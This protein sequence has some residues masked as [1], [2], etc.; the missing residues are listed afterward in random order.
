[1]SH[2]HDQ[3]LFCPA[4]G[5]SDVA[6][7]PAAS[8]QAWAK[9]PDQIVVQETD[10]NP[11]IRPESRPGIRPE[12]FTFGFG[13]SPQ[14]QRIRTTAQRRAE[15]PLNWGINSNIFDYINGW[16]P[17]L[18]EGQLP[19][20]IRDRVPWSGYLPAQPAAGTSDRIYEDLL[21]SLSIRRNAWGVGFASLGAHNDDGVRA[22]AHT[23]SIPDG[24]VV[25]DQCLG[26]GTYWQGDQGFYLC[27]D[28]YAM[29]PLTQPP[30]RAHH[31]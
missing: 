22:P 21:L 28:G 17:R 16:H 15:A 26:T 30:R 2:F 4:G 23:N 3:T 5:C 25:M 11:S 27:V 24:W 18:T 20:V 10:F 19:D 12:A 7:A 6:L 9:V 29:R 13:T 1:M 14:I 31:P 8:A